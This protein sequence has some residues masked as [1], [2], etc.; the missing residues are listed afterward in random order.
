M[1]VGVVE[2]EEEDWRPFLMLYASTVRCVLILKRYIMHEAGPW[3]GSTRPGRGDENSQ[4][5]TKCFI[6]K[7]PLAHV[8]YFT[9]QLIH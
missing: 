2:E 5:C 7:R 4:T 8:T 6:L 1:D 3:E 9:H